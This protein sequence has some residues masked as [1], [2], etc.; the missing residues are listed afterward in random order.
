MSDYQWPDIP[1][2]LDNPIVFMDA[3]QGNPR[4]KM[5]ADYEGEQWIFQITNGQWMTV[6]KTDERDP[7]FIM[8]PLNVP[9][10]EPKKP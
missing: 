1:K 8:C 2:Y 7:L 6:R 9:S 10:Q 4:I 5:V 3:N